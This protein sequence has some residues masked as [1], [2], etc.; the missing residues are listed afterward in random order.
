MELLF[1]KLS[2]VAMATK[3]IR[4]VRISASSSAQ[5]RVRS[6][7]KSTMVSISR[8]C[9]VALVLRGRRRS[10]RHVGTTRAAAKQQPRS[11]WPA[12]ERTVAS[13]AGAPRTKALGGGG[14]GWAQRPWLGAARSTPARQRRG[15]RAAAARAPLLIFFFAAPENRHAFRTVRNEFEC[16]VFATAA[17]ALR[18]GRRALAPRRKEADEAISPRSEP[19][20]FRLPSHQV[21]VVE[22]RVAPPP[23]AGGTRG[24]G[25]WR[26][27]VTIKTWLCPFTRP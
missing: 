8:V 5:G 11:G 25:Q 22:E 4:S 6:T 24:M 27:R 16:E 13:A 1:E 12:R 21:C 10:R 26:W 2:C 9:S 3:L 19:L 14:S 23:H 17:G 20:R 7:P 18:Q 15:G